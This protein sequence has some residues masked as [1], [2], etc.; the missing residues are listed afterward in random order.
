MD[1]QTVTCLD[2]TFKL[3][4]P[5]SDILNDIKTVAR[6]L[7]EDYAGKNPIF[8]A[9]L[10]GSFMFAADLL[11]EVTVPCEISFVKVSS[12]Q[13][14]ESTGNVRELVGLKEDIAGRHVVV[15]E[16]IVDTGNT[17]VALFEMLKAKAPASLE[18]ATLLQKPDC[19]QHKIDAKYVGRNIPNDFVIGY[20]L[21]YNGQGRNLR[22]IYV[23]N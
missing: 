15:L 2:R 18:I 4:L 14:T 22:N 20:G 17:V 19:L 23:V 7:N 5:E 21:D 11:K 10:N 1:Q 12:Y 16:D 6:K 13:N 3:Y 9:I 8:V